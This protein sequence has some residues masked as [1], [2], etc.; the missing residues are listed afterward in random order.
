[1]KSFK[2]SVMDLG[3]DVANNFVSSLSGGLNVDSALLGFKKFLRDY[4]IKAY[5][6]TDSMKSE[7][8]KIGQGI[9]DYIM[10]KNGGLETISN[11][12]KKTYEK[13][14]GNI[15]KADE[16]LDK[17][18]GKEKEKEVKDTGDTITKELSKIES[19]MDSFKKK[20]VSDLGG[21]IASQPY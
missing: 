9:A 20:T 17:I 10:G 3:G 4:I 18:F 14:A 21:D 2:D 19:A 5:V 12:F 16:Y 1:M 6:F 8:E 7:I 15:S 13:L 11:E